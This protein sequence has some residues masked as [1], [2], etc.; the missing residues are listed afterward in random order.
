M[1]EVFSVRGLFVEAQATLALY[2]C[3]KLTGVAVDCGHGTGSRVFWGV[4]PHSLGFGEGLW[5]TKLGTGCG[6]TSVASSSFGEL[7][8]LFLS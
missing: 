2:A 8:S 3:N 4:S 7:S 5:L 6:P 1:F